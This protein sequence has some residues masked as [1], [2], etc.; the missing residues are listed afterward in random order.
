VADRL[1]ELAQAP[2][3]QRAR[4]PSTPQQSQPPTPG[5]TATCSGFR[6]KMDSPLP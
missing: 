2:V 4:R 1:V 3:A 5:A 6:I